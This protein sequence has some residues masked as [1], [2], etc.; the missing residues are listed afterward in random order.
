[1]AFA[2]AASAQTWRPIEPAH[3]AMKTPGIDAQADAEVLYW[4]VRIE[5]RVQ[6]PDI[7]VIYSHYIYSHY[8]RTKIFTDKGAKDQGTVEIPY[9]SR[10]NISDFAARTIQPDGTIVDLQR[11]D[12]R[13]SDVYKG[14]K[15]A[16]RK[17]KSLAFPAVKPGSIIEYRYRET[18]MGEF[19]SHVALEFSRE[20]PVHEV[21]Y[22]IKPLQVDWLPFRMRNMDFTLQRKPFKMEP[23][24]LIS[25]AVTSSQNIPAFEPELHMPPGQDA[26]PWMFIYYEGLSEE[27]VGKWR[28]GQLAKCVM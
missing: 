13:E 20:L 24:G 14:K 26:R 25:Y 16:R 2:A 18:R 27:F 23:Q 8:L 21:K 6:L 12:M 28:F 4:E 5:D 1:M 3:L 7:F 10:T 17:V 19:A 22:M 9:F 11:D 15:R